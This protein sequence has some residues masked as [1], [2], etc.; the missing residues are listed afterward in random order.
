MIANGKSSGL[1]G[2][3]FP[4]TSS[5]SL[6]RPS[7]TTQPRIGL[8][9]AMDST[10]IK[11]RAGLQ[12]HM[13]L[14]KLSLFDVGVYVSIHF[15]ANYETGVW[16]G[17]A[18]KILAKCP[19]GSELRRIQRSIAQLE[20]I[21][22]LKCFRRNHGSRGNFACVINKYE[23]P[24]GALK[25]HRVNAEKSTSYNDVCYERCADGAVTTR[26]ADADVTPIQE[27][28]V[29]SRVR[30]EESKPCAPTA[31]SACKDMAF[32]AF[33]AR[34][35]NSPTWDGSDYKALDDL[36]HKKPDLGFSEFNQRWA[37]FL[38]SDDP[39]DVKQGFRLRYFCAN[40]DRFTNEATNGRLPVSK[41]TQRNESSDAALRRMATRFLDRGGPDTKAIPSGDGRRQLGSIPSG[42]SRPV[43][44]RA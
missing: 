18:G 9:L 26:C 29:R 25:G 27:V 11:L 28:E 12:E 35:G 15:Q 17:S 14:G 21:G 31:Q 20:A 23:V 33:K 3:G 2:D 10:F 34:T 40:F 4:P 1:C 42:D 8:L 7:V 37:N 41:S 43:S 16:I 38:G 22:F 30:K 36:F 13:E 44:K 6:D 24:F 39:F 32:T 19:K 5:A